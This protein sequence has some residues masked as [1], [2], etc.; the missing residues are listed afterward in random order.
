VDYPVE[1]S[2]PKDK[3]PVL[4]SFLDLCRRANFERAS[5][6]VLA[7]KPIRYSNFL[8]GVSASLSYMDWE[9]PKAD[10]QQW[11]SILKTLDRDLRE[12]EY[13]GYKVR[14]SESFF[15]AMIEFT[16]F[17]KDTEIAPGDVAPRPPREVV[18]AKLYEK[19]RLLMLQG[20]Y[21]QAYEMT[22]PGESVPK[23]SR[24]GQAKYDI[25]GWGNL[26][27][28]DRVEWLYFYFNLLKKGEHEDYIQ[29]IIASENKR[30][31]NLNLFLLRYLALMAKWRQEKIRWEESIR[32]FH[33]IE[34]AIRSGPFPEAK[35]FSE[36]LQSEDV[37]LSNSVNENTINYLKYL[38]NVK[39]VEGRYY[40][41]IY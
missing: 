33:L 34:N 19:T 37:I 40:V 41:E 2:F 3:I 27:G 32:T 24:W 28:L 22:F 25:C 10:C 20:E 6:Y 35:F 13:N 26:R 30:Y 4:Q 1:V 17:E 8:S 7:E 39:E 12:K 29:E 31:Y 18:L 16:E 5:N 14:L 15:E 38:W 23:T 11:I 9:M 21:K 36:T